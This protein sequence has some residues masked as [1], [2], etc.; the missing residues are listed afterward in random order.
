MKMDY[1]QEEAEQTAMYPELGLSI[2]YSTMKLC[3]EAGEFAEKVGKLWR[4][5]NKKLIK[6]YDVIDVLA[7]VKELGDILWYIADIATA[8]QIPLSSIAAVNLE[9]LRD[10]AN[11]GVIKSEGDDR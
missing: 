6:D 9:K 11:R 5:Q 8:L 10:R 3:G 1:Y 2:H 4:N 7:L